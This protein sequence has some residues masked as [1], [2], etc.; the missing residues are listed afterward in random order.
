MTAHTEPSS[1]SQSSN[2]YKPSWGRGSFAAALATGAFF[3]PQAVPLEWFPLN[4]PGTDINYLEIS[5]A[6]DKPGEVQI[7]YNLSTGIT[8]LNSI[9]IPVSPTEQTYTYTFPL[10]DAPITELRIDPLPMGGTLTVRQMRIINRRGEEIRRFPRDMFRPLHEIA[11]ISP[12]PDGWKIVSTPTATDPYARLELLAP[13]IPVGMDHRNLLR[14]LLSTGYLAMMLLI[15][16]LAVLFATYRPRSWRDFFLHAGF[17]ATLALLFSFVGNRGLIRNSIQ[18]ARFEVPALPPGMNLEMDLTTSHPAQ[19]QLFWDNGRGYS[20]ADSRRVD[21]ER[22]PG[23]QTLRFALPVQ[24][25]KALRFD[26]LDG[27][28]RLRIRALRIVDSA[29]NTRLSLPLESLMA[30]HQIENLGLDGEEHLLLETNPNATDPI[31]EFTPAAV[32]MINRAL[33]GQPKR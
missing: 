14:C 2:W 26:P 19:A 29:Q 12:L 9:R 27:A 23:L 31:A 18:Y 30:S 20:E 7:F 3:L 4:E 10:P 15:L 16:L 21:Y 28:A 6:A 22:Q 32:T 25:L 33:A 8:E 17:L 13:I 24:S 11:E 5:C 1:A